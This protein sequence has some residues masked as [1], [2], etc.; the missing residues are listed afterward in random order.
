MQSDSNSRPT[1][2]VLLQAESPPP[3]PLYL[4][5]RKYKAML[6]IT[7]KH[8]LGRY[9]RKHLN[10][11]LFNDGLITPPAAYLQGYIRYSAGELT[12]WR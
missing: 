9:V 4:T 5:D 3:H 1:A 6:L 12:I 7:K 8:L 11:L 2:A 10:R